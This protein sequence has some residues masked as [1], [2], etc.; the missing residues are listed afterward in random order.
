MPA[1][2]PTKYKDEYATDEFIDEFV[3]TCIE[4]NK[5]VSVCALAVYIKV[6][7]ETLQNWGKGHAEFLR[8]LGRINQTSKEMLCSGG[9]NSSYN[10]TIAK[11]ILSANHGMSERNITQHEGLEAIM[12]VINVTL[13]QENE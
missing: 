12:P 11:L 1:G 7:E 8:S 3:K 5:L 13:T 6:T 4:K 2:R 10:S 9:L